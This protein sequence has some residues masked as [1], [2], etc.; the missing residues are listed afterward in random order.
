MKAGIRLALMAAIAAAL[1]AGAWLAIRGKAPDRRD[2]GALVTVGGDL[3]HDALHPA[4]DLTRMG[5]AEEARLGAEIDLQVRSS[6]TVG[7]DAATEA[8]LARVL[9]LLTPGALRR[10]ITYSVALV[11]TPEVNAFA[12]AGGRLYVTEGMMRFAASEAE[13]AV[14][15]GH[16]VSHVDLRHCVERLQLERVARRIDPGLGALARLGYEV[17]LLGFSEEQELAADGNGALVAARATYDPWQAEPMLARLSTKEAGTRRKPTRDPVAEAVAVVPEMLRRYLE[18]HPPAD[19]RIETVRRVLK[20][21]PDLWRGDP[22]YIGRANL[23]THR[24]LAD[25]PLSG[26]WITR[27]APPD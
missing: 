25:G 12:V 27:A 8:Y 16:E 10:E 3:A 21:H 11:R 2:L 13:L 5:A 26:E 18:T 4:V 6:M 7:G 14:V 23:A 1:G 20:G 9:S 15:L 17:M 19:Q 22:R 24:A